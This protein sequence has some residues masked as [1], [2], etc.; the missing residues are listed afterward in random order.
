MYIILSLHTYITLYTMTIGA[1]KKGFSTV[2]KSPKTH[3]DEMSE[4][5]R[6]REN[7]KVCL[8]HTHSNTCIRK[9][10]AASLPNIFDDCVNTV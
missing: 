10:L 5:K 4:W 1:D 2:E 9:D 6:E 7:G 8:E 3:L